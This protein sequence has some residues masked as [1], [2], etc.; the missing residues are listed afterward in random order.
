ME[1]VGWGKVAR[2]FNWFDDS[3]HDGVFL[4]LGGHIYDKGLYAHASSRYVFPVAEKWQRFR[5]TIGLRDGAS[6]QGSAIFIVRG[7]GKELYYSP[8]LRAGGTEE[9]DLEIAGV[10]ELELLADG[11]EG[12]NHNC[13]AIWAAPRVSR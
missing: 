4:R 8:I 9:I 2:N 13:W 10:K 11:A 3:I 12:H 5:A 6:A 1:K 7:D